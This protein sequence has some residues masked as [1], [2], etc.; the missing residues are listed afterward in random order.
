MAT[1]VASRSSNSLKGQRDPSV[2]LAH[3]Q[4]SVQRAYSASAW[5]EFMR[6]G[7]SN[8][9]GRYGSSAR[10]ICLAAGRFHRE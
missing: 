1:C 7:S 2:S 8:Q 10:A 5:G 9:V 6:I 3:T 4:M